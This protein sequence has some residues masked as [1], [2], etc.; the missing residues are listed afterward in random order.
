MI[1]EV[2]YVHDMKIGLSETSSYT[3]SLKGN[4]VRIVVF[5]E[6][7]SVTLNGRS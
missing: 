6:R 2:R 4:M 3:G 7:R 1:G 5:F